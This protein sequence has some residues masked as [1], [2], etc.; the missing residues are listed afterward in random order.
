MTVIFTLGHSTRDLADFS[1]VLQAHDIHLLV[2]IRALPASRRMP[3]FNRQHLELWLPEIG[4][5][6]LWEKDLG[7]KRGRQMAPEAS[8]HIALKEEAFRNYADYTL[9]RPFQQAMDRLVGMA[10]QHSTVIMCAERDFR[11]CHRRIVSDC[12]LNLE[13]TV[14]HILDESPPMVHKLT[15]EARIIDGQVVYRGDLLFG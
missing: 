5:D 14:L 11:K 13:H 9:T 7:G 2:D 1:R 3:H 12:L 8:P 10:E 4:C 15:A 6:Y